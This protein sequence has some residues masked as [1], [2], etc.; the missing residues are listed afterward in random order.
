MG[1]TCGGGPNVGNSGGE[2]E[3]TARRALGA[4]HDDFGAGGH[5]RVNTTAVE[6][7]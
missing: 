7:A 2:F 5:G 1:T 4:A 6:S 3:A